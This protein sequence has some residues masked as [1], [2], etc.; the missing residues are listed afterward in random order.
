MFISPEFIS[1]I[2]GGALGISLSYPFSTI[3]TRSQVFSSNGLKYKLI[4]DLKKSGFRNCLYPGFSSPFVGTIAEK[5]VL[6]YTFGWLDKNTGL[7]DFN[8]GL[9]AGF[10]TTG[11]VTPYERIMISCQV[12]NIKPIIAIKHAFIWDGPRS[13]FRGWTGTLFREV[14]GYGIYFYTFNKCN[15]FIPG[16][17]S[18][19]IMGIGALSGISAWAFIYPTDPIKT[20]MQNDGKTFMQ[21]I[22]Q[23]RNQGDF[24]SG[25]TPAL[26]RAGILHSGVFLGYTTALSFLKSIN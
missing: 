23:I 10:T 4:T 18:L 21:A 5:S 24:Y 11:I 22:K 8:K 19:K 1:G 25:F 3:K 7:S 6:F 17:S 16:D 13:L 26:I 2:C 9:L 20:I 12:K 15:K 14:P